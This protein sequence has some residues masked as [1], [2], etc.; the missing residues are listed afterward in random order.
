MG[1]L[2]DVKLRMAKKSKLLSLLQVWIMVKIIVET[3]RAKDIPELFT[4]KITVR[5]KKKTSWF[6]FFSSQQTQKWNSPLENVCAVDGA[7]LPAKQLPE[8]QAR[9]IFSESKEKRHLGKPLWIVL[10]TGTP[11]VEEG[12]VVGVCPWCVWVNNGL[13]GERVPGSPWACLALA[14]T[15]MWRNR[16]TASHLVRSPTANEHLNEPGDASV[17]C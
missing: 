4:S 5:R 6:F 10:V 14:R 9:L 1:T 13:F 15:Q 3:A 8:S 2:T 7:F 16:N 12:L 17:A 11:R